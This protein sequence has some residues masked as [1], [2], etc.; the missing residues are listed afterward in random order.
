VRLRGVRDHGGRGQS[1]PRRLLSFFSI[2][3]QLFPD[4]EAG[5]HFEFLKPDR[6]EAVLLDLSLLFFDQKLFGV[7]RVTGLQRHLACYARWS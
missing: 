6:Y 2:S 7:G 4:L 3:R 1:S 5:L